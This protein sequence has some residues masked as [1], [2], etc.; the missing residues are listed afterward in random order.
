MIVV[1]MTSEI[2]SPREGRAAQLIQLFI[3][4]ADP[5]LSLL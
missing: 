3:V 4:V 5:W 2:C 1:F